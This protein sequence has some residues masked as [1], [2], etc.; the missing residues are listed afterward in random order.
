MTVINTNVKSLVAQASLAANN[1]NLST[2]MERLSTGSRINSAKDDAAGLAISSRMTSQVRG[3]NVAIRNANDGISLAQTAE[4]AME[5]TTSM[6]QRMRELTLQATNA[7]YTASDRASLQEEVSQLQAEIDRIAST[8]QFN[9]QNILDGSFTGRQLQIG[10]NASTTMGISINAVNGGTLGQ[11]ADGPAISATRASLAVQ[12]MS[13]LASD[14]QNK[15]FSVAVNGTTSNVQLPQAVAGSAVSA[16]IIAPAVGSDVGVA[17]SMV[18]GT[19]SFKETTIDLTTQAKRV[20]ELRANNG[21]YQQIDITNALAEALGTSVANVNVAS[22]STADEVT[23]EQFVSAV[24][25]AIDDTGAFTGDNKVTVSVNSSGNVIFEAAGAGEVSLAESTNNGVTGTFVATFVK[26]GL[27]QP[28]NAIDLSSPVKGGFK[29]AVNGGTAQEIDLSSFLANTNYVKNIAAVTAPELVNV[30]QMALDE[31]FSGSNK[32]TVGIDNDG[33]LML[34]VAGGARQAVITDNYA[35]ASGVGTATGATTLWGASSNT[36]TVDNDATTV[37]MAALG[38]D[39]VTTAFGD[40]DTAIKVTVNAEQAVNIDL[41]SYI[42][43]AAADTSAVTQSEMRNALQAAF[44]A[45]FTGANAI[46]VNSF[47]DGKLGFK[48]NGG[49]GYL[50][51][52]NYTPLTGSGGTF[53]TKAITSAASLT[54]NPLVGETEGKGTALYSV[55]SNSVAITDVFSQGNRNSLLATFKDQTRPLTT[56][57]L[58]GTITSGDTIAFT[59]NSVS[60]SAYTVTAAD[61]AD[62][63][64]ETLA[65]NLVNHANSTT[66]FA[67][68]A[69]ASS[70]GGVISFT[71]MT[72]GGGAVSTTVTGGNTTATAATT[73]ATQSSIVV[74]ASQDE[75]LTIALDGATGK[76]ISLTAGTYGSLEDLAAEINRVASSSGLFEGNDAIRAVVLEGYDKYNADA[77][78]D[79]H[80]YLAIQSLTGKTVTVSDTFV[81]TGKMFGG[82]TNSMV[83][84][85][86]ILDSLPG[87]Q[88]G[89]TTSGLTSGGVD[90][91]VGSGAFT[92]QVDTGS[93][94]VSRAVVLS[95]QNANQSFADFAQTLQDDINTALLADGHSVTVGYANGA[96]SVK[97]DQAGA[98]TI[99]L[100]GA[101]ISNV[102]GQSTVSGTGVDASTRDLTSMDDVIAA[103]NDDLNASNAGATASFDHSTGTMTFSVS[104]GNTGSGSTISLSGNDLSSLQFGTSLSATGAAGNATHA[105]IS[106]I[107]V[108]TESGAQAALASIDNALNYVSI[109][110]SKLGAIQNRLDHTVSNLTNAVVNTEASRSRIMDADYGA[111]SANLAKAQIIQQAATAMLAQANQSAQSVLSLLQ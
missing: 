37:N 12:G 92:V 78:A 18:V 98:S 16:E 71:T 88:F 21:S 26:S 61:I 8:T 47:A 56:V 11:R 23:A 111:E 6:L 105:S 55:L 66:S 58:A 109:E 31:K 64:Y 43:A 75:D 2:A 99:S 87:K 94:S 4:G 54:V 14:Y 101:V 57:T 29:V 108:S 34:D 9:G 89:Y 96:F 77:P 13:T 30:I 20:F 7:T 90:S 68:Q 84:F 100:T 46:Q 45:N 15:A 17:P 82:E 48:V 39:S 83:N 79:V 76:Q 22:L 59:A 60:T 62:T 63:T 10:D 104:S 53:V 103:I 97:L 25:K 27:I 65:K 49:S 95:S 102:F 36:I 3:L 107:D 70:V 72:T 91:T 69:I 32:L 81:S 86:G 1:K 50:K 93:S 110:R 35:M 80:K 38:I 85:T 106:E 28:V 19:L 74:T 51:L 24:Q 5:E 41:A 52:E 44:D 42:K 73:K 40:A 33:K 67:A